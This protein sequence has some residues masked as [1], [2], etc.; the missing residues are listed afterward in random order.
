MNIADQL[1]EARMQA[2][3]AGI[4]PCFARLGRVKWVAWRKWVRNEVGATA[5]GKSQYETFHGM[6]IVPTVVPG[7]VIAEEPK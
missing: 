3:Q 1:V 4:I 2:V 7:I 5:P 6:V